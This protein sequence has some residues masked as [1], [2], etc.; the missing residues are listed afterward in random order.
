MALK[1]LFDQR[2]AL[3]GWVT[4]LA[5]LVAMYVAIWPSMRGQPSM[6]DF[7]DQ[8]PEAM[9][10]LF[11]TT[12]ADLSTPVGYL[13]VE[14]LSFM[15]PLVLML[16]TVT[17][18]A[19]AVAGE[20]DRRTMD[21]LLS[22]PVSRSRVVVEKLMAMCVGVLLLAAV[23]L[24]SLMGGGALADM[25][26]SWPDVT[27]A[28]LHMA[29][30]ALVFGTLALAVGGITGHATLSRAVPA[31]VAVVAYVV[32]GLA[33]VVSWLEPFQK[34]SP[35]YQYIGHDPLRHGVSWSSV[36]VAVTTVVVLAVVAVLGF[37]RR[38]VLS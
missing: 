17:A 26:L 9:R 23:G 12:G 14:L 7:L 24:V 32:N 29:L 21:M 18:G 25:G 2:R 34:L 38:D 28:M 37:R 4:S 15:G 13:Q 3:V 11:A 20:E 1:T 5:L 6:S 27:A 36:A 30:L 31:V 22:T 8:M 19:A 33:P 10:S 16:Y 35:F